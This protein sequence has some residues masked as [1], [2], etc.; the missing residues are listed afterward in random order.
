MVETFSK[1][2]M[3]TWK[4]LDCF[5]F[6]EYQKDAEL[7]WHPKQFFGI[8]LEVVMPLKNDLSPIFPD[9]AWNF[10]FPFK[11]PL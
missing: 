6:S 9:C 7:A 5:W 8:I 4:K 11:N 10:K 3:E 2:A 1:A